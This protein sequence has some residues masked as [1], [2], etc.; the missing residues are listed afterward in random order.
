MRPVFLW[1]LFVTASQPTHAVSQSLFA[2]ILQE[3]KAL[4]VLGTPILIAQLAQMANGVIDTM[5]AGHASA[6]DLAAVGIGTSIWIP[7]LLF[8]FGTLGALQPLVSEHRG[9]E[10]LSRIM[11][12]TWQGI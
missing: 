9:A 5:M 12:L 10:R 4:A 7:V 3:W 2:Q 1:Y 8:F 11:P 6:R